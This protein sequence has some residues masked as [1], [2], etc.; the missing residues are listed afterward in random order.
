MQ[1][2][3]GEGVIDVRPIKH[4]CL[5]GDSRA[6]VQGI[7][8]SLILRSREAASR[9]MAAGAI[10]AAGFETRVPRSSP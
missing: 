3:N 8:L 1:A 2:W 6:P 9:R 5:V 7:S 10:G 4:I